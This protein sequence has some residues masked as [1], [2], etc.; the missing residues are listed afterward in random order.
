VLEKSPQ[1]RFLALDGASMSSRGARQ[2]V[3]AQGRIVG[4]RIEFQVRPNPFSGVQFRRVGWKEFR[5]EVGVPGQ[6]DIHLPGFVRTEPVPEQDD[7]ARQMLIQLAQEA[8]DF[9]RV[10]IGLRVESEAESD[11]I[12]PRRDRERPDHGDF[13]VRVSALPEDRRLALSGPSA[14]NQRRHQHAGFVQESQVR[15][16]PMAFFLTRGH[17]SLIQRPMASSSRST[18]RRSGRWA[19]HPSERRT[20]PI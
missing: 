14:P 2:V 7:G 15:L 17:C 11:A 13:L 20:R 16:Q 8:G 4:H 6:K 3:K 5:M 12:S 10:D 9:L 1:E 19:L 18:A